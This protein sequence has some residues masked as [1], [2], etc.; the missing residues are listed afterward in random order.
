MNATLQ[1]FAKDFSI[2]NCQASFFFPDGDVITPKVHK[3]LLPTLLQKNDFDVFPIPLPPGI[4]NEIPRL[5]LKTKLDDT[6][7]EIA[8]ARINFHRKLQAGGGSKI[9]LEQFPELALPAIKIFLD[10]FKPRVD[11]VGLVITRFSQKDKP[12]ERL[13]EHFCN[14]AIRGNPVKRTDSFEIHSHKVYK[15]PSKID[16][17]S[18]VR[19]KSALLDPGSL[20]AIIV[21]QDINTLGDQPE[22]T[23]YSYQKITDFLKDATSES[24]D[25]F[26]KYFEG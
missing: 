16:V 9:L 4:P 25:I 1:I 5:V 10:Y 22:T 17:N 26:H 8:P 11:R 6:R 21:E 15:M 3:D 24:E 23:D 13:A 7:I 14:P 2:L 20:P 12:A 18:W 19:C